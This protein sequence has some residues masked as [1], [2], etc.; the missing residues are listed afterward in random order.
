MEDRVS[1]D[2]EVEEIPMSVRSASWSCSR[3]FPC[4]LD[5]GYYTDRPGSEGLLQKTTGDMPLM[6][7]GDMPP[8][9]L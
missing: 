9:I 8:E 4:T 3:F 2:L 6:V 7:F 5:V 1:S